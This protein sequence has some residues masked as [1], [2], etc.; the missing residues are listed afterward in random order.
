MSSVTITKQPLLPVITIKKN[1]G[2]L[3]TFSHFLGTYNFRIR[4]C[5]FTPPI[6]SVGGKFNITLTSSDGSQSGL[7]T[8]LTA[9]NEGNEVTIWIGKTDGTKTKAFLG[10]IETTEIIQPNKNYFDLKISGPDWGSYILKSRIVAR[11]W[12]QKRNGTA[13]DTTDNTTLVSQIVDD[14][15][16]ETQS[17]PNNDY[18][19]VDSG[20]VFSSSNVTLPTIRLPDFNANYEKLDDKLAVLDDICG[21]IHYVD[22][23]KVFYMK[24]QNISASSAPATILFTDDYTDSI[25]TGWDQTK[26][27][28]IGPNATYVRTLENH[29]RKI[30]GLGGN[31]DQVDI[32]ASSTTSS[33]TLETSHLAVKF[34]PTYTTVGNIGVYIAKVGTPTSNL[35]VDL[36]EDNG[37]V[38]TGNII[39]SVQIDK[40][41]VGTS[42]PSL[43]NLVKI[44]DE[45]N[46][47][48]S[49]WI[50]LQKTGD[51]SN[52]YRWYHDNTD[53]NP[54]PSATSSD[55][56]TWTATSTPNRFK[57]SHATWTSTPIVSVLA[58]SGLS[59]TSKHFV[60][61][62]IRKADL[63]EFKTVTDLLSVE[64]LVLMKKKEIFKGS[65]YAPDIILQSGQRVRI[66]Q[67]SAGYTFDAVF[68]LGEITYIFESSDDLATGTTWFEVQATRYTTYT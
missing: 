2:S 37:G 48:R 66:R 19:V 10:I 67:N 30:F 5:E 54:S 65:I 47:G 44:N 13:L 59:A 34:T 61:D 20:L 11:S 21:T 12:T 50:V 7:N 64:A 55:D 36:R 45:I 22:P 58:D 8:I 53:N 28:L 56:I 62:V 52:T 3:Y 18:S 49:Y 15:L 24:Q 6:D 9:I 41:A 14:L 40:A 25:A 16:T 29:K 38:P 57:Y 63:T 27:G 68:T 33:T 26:V 23:D 46:T 1:D 42:A 60:E 17:Y 43:P 31:K 51:A 4:R 35:I 32:N 39:R